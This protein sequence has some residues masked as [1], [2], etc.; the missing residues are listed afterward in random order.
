MVSL[1]TDFTASDKELT[2]THSYHRRVWWNVVRP[3]FAEYQ[4]LW[5]RIAKLLAT[6]IGLFW[7]E[8]IVCTEE[9]L[10]AETG[11][12]IAGCLEAHM[13]WS[14]AA[15]FQGA[16]EFRAAGAVAVAGVY[17]ARVVISAMGIDWLAR[18]LYAFDATTGTFCWI[19]HTLMIDATPTVAGAAI[20]HVTT[21][22]CRDAGIAR[23]AFRRRAATAVIVSLGILATI[24]VTTTGF[25][26]AK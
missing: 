18:S 20:A 19:R 23:T 17:G 25:T 16:I 9:R 15:T 14:T 8:L 24:A 13:G 3:T 6:C 26:A 12:R 1:A 2:I 7:C 10:D 21:A 5:I 11:A 22:I 4:A